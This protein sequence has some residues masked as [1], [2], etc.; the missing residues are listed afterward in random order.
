MSEPPEAQPAEQP[1]ADGESPEAQ[2]KPRK[3]TRRRILL[4]GGAA[5]AATMG[6]LSYWAWWDQAFGV[7][8]AAMPDHRVQ[9]PATAPSRPSRISR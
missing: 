7:R 1:E 2:R 5:T 9:L 3:L 4:Y 8:V 6:A